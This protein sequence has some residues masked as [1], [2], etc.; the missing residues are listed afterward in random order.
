MLI[1]FSYLNCPIVGLFHRYILKIMLV[2]CRDQKLD[3][4]G[5]LKHTISSSLSL[6]RVFF[7]C[8]EKLRSLVNDRFELWITLSLWVLSCKNIKW[9]E[10]NS[11]IF[12][13]MMVNQVQVPRLLIQIHI[14]QYGSLNFISCDDHI[15]W[16]R[17]N[18]FVL[19]SMVIR[20]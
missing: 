1:C 13:K 4:V 10:L 17:M 16:G 2:S 8:K 14:H 20:K 15:V 5:I 11:T 3:L 19:E 18:I 6:F 9:G 7:I 12:N